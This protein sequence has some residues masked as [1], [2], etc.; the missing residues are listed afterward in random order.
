MKEATISLVLLTINLSSL[1]PALVQLSGT[2]Y[3]AEKFLMYLS[4][5]VPGASPKPENHPLVDL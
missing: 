5:Q 2:P 1:T 3:L 4:A